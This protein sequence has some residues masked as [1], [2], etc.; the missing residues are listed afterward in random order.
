MEVSVQKFTKQMETNEFDVE[1]CQFMTL[2]KIF[3]LPSVNARSP[4]RTGES[5]VTMNTKIYFR[6]DC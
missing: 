4:L 5:K 3:S 2:F 1:F 6:L